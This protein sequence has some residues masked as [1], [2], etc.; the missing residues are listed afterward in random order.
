MACE[1]SM[2]WLGFIGW[3]LLLSAL[4]DVQARDAGQWVF[5][6]GL[7]LFWRQLAWVLI[8]LSTLH[9]IVSFMQKRSA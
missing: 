8:G 5:W 2:R 4:Q 6:L 7:L 3:V 9:A 1:V